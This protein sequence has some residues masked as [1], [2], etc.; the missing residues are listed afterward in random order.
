V[1]KT[2]SALL[3][4]GYRLVCGGAL[5]DEK[6]GLSYARVTVTSSKSVVS[7]FS[8]LLHVVKRMHICMYVQYMQGLGQSRLSTA[9]HA[10]LLFASA[11]TAV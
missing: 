1:V 4:V 2:I 7:M 6:T 10:P 3:C 5:S 8:L 11:T 9:D